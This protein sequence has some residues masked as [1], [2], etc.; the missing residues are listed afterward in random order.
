M[1][2]HSFH[3]VRPDAYHHVWDRDLEPA[4][5]VEPGTEVGFE[6]RD[7]SDEQ[8]S[9]DSTRADVASLDFGRVNPVCGP[10][11]VKGAQPGDALEVEIL[12]FTPRD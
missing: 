11:F 9:P 6:V 5:E 4:L 2:D 1:H 10:V 3:H 7:A 12:D 8:L